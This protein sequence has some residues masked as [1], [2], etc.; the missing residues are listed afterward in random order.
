M[1]ISIFFLVVALLCFACG[2]WSRWWVAPQPYY[3]A[4]ISGGL[5]FWVLSIL[6]PQIAK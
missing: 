6:W 4:W 5:F 1:S 2:A 3:P